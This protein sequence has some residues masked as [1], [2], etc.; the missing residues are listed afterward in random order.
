MRRMVGVLAVAA[1]ALC[2]GEE[3]A[4]VEMCAPGDLL[5]RWSFSGDLLDSAGGLEGA[6]SGAA[7][8]NDA[9]S[10]SAIT[11]RGGARGTSCVDLGFG[12]FPS[13]GG[14]VTIEV[15]ATQNAFQNYSRV[16]DIGVDSEEYLTVTWSRES[17]PGT[18][19]EKLKAGTVDGVFLDSN[20]MGGFELGRRFHV[21]L[22]LLPREDGRTEA[23]WAKRDAE[24][25]ALLGGGSAVTSIRWS[26]KDLAGWQFLL[27][28]S[29]YSNDGDASATYDEVRV[30]KAAL[31]E[32][33]LATSARM[34]A[35]RLPFASA[36]EAT[37]A[38]AA[39]G[40]GTV[41]MAGGAPGAAASARLG[42]AETAQ[43]A[44][45][46]VEGAAFLR[47]TGDLYAIARGEATNPVVTVSGARDAALAA[48]FIAADEPATAV[49]TGG[50]D[51]ASPSDPANWECR[52]YAGAVI[53]GAVPCAKTAVTISGATTFSCPRGQSL[54]CASLVVTNCA[55]AADC[56][57]RGLGSGFRIC[58]TLNLNGHR[59]QTADIPG[60]GTI[61]GD[62]AL[63][64]SAQPPAI[65]QNAC[66]WL[67]AADASTIERDAAGNVLSWTSKDSAHR[68]ARPHTIPGTPEAEN[69]ASAIAPSYG[70]LWGLP[71][72]DFGATGSRR[73][74]LYD[75]FTNLRTVFLAIRIDRYSQRAFL[76]GDRNNGSGVYNFHRGDQGQYGHAK[77]SIYSAVWDGPSQVVPYSDWLDTG[78][79]VI[80]I[81]TSRNACSDSLTD[82]RHIYDGQRTGGRHLFELVCFDTVLADDD[83]QAVAE[84]LR[85]KWM[86]SRAP[87]VLEVDVE[88]GRTVANSEM[89]ILANARFVKSG[90]GTFR[91]ARVQ[92][93][94][95][96]GTEIAAGTYVSTNNGT[97]QDSGTCE[98]EILVR[99][100]AALELPGT[101]D[102]C[103]YHFA[104]DG[105][106]IRYTG[107]GLLGPGTSQ[108][109]T[110]TLSAD[111][112]I[113]RFDFIGAGYTPVRADLGGRVLTFGGE[114]SNI[115]NTELLNGTLRK[116]A[117]LLV[118]DK[119]SLRATS[120]GLDIGCPL[121]L[122]VGGDVGN[123][124]VRTPAVETAAAGNGVL[125]VHGAYRPE[126]GYI[127]NFA[128]ADGS[129]LDVS[130]LDGAF[131]SFNDLTG[132]AVS[133]VSGA[134]V[135]VDA[136]GRA[137][138]AGER[139]VAWRAAPSG[140]TFRWDDATAAA[141][142]AQPVAAADGLYCGAPGEGVVTVAHWTGGA[143]DGD[144]ANA[145]NWACTNST[146]LAVA[147]G[148]PGAAAEVHLGGSVDAQFPE[149]AEVR[150]LGV[151]VGDC[152][153]AADCDWRG[154]GRAVRFNG[155]VDLLGHKLRVRTLKGAGGITDSSLPAGEAEAGAS[156]G[157]LHIDV[158]E[159]ASEINTTVSIGGNLRLVKDGAGE[160]LPSKTEQGFIGGTLVAGG[161]LRMVTSGDALT[162]A[163][164]LRELGAARSVIEVK[165]GAEFDFAGNYDCRQ[166]A[167]LLDGGTIANRGAD[168]THDAYGSGHTLHLA[169]DSRMDMDFTYMNWGRYQGADIEF[170]FGG[171]TLDATL[172]AGKQ[173][174]FF[175]GHSV[176]NGT[177]RLSGDGWLRVD[178]AASD[179]RTADFVMDG[180][181]FSLAY[182]LSVRDYVV[183]RDGGRHEG[184]AALNVHGRFAP[185]GGGFYPCTLQ[186][187]STL[188]LSACE[189]T[190]CAESFSCPGMDV[191]FARNAEVA[192]ELGER[193]PAA[194]ERLVAWREKPV[195]AE[196]KWSEATAAR[197][198]QPLLATE[199]GLFYGGEGADTLVT[200]AQWTGGGG[201][202]DL[203]N[204]ANWSCRNAAGAAVAGGVPGAA[205]TVRVEGLVDVQFP[206]GSEGRYAS[207][208]IGDCR[209]AADCD[210]RG[211]EAPI[212]STVDLDGH[213]LH[214]SH[215]RGSGEIT[216]V[217][218]LDSSATAP[219]VTASAVFWLDAADLS[220][221]AIDGDG[222]VTSWT[223]KDSSR[224]V[225][226]ATSAPAWNSDTWGVPTVDFGAAGSGKDMTYARLTGL[227]T[228]F[229]AIK[230]PR[231]QAAFLLGD[232]STFNFHRGANGQYGSN[233]NGWSQYAAIWNGT[234]P[235]TIDSEYLPD[236]TF[237][238]VCA[239]MKTGNS[240]SLTSDRNS[241]N[242]R[243]GG[244]QLSELICFNAD[245]GD[246][247][248][249]A[250]TEYLQKKWLSRT[251]E[252]H[253]HVPE[254]ET[255]RDDNIRL[256]LNL[257]FVKDGDG[258]YL[259]FKTDHSYT[260]GTEVAGGYMRARSNA[261]PDGMG[262][263][264]AVRG[265]AVFDIDGRANTSYRVGPWGCVVTLDGGTV[266]NMDADLLHGWTMLGNMRLE[267]DSTILA[268][269]SFGF[270][271]TGHNMATIDLGGHE[272][273]VELGD[274]K[275]FCLHNMTITEGRFTVNGGRWLN[276]E[277]TS[278]RAAQA[279][280]DLECAVNVAV[281][282]TM[283]DYT[284]RNAQ[285]D[286]AGTA[287]L[288]VYGAFRPL[289]DF[290]YGC[291]LQNGATLDISSRTGEWSVKS[292]SAG[293]LG[294]VTFAAGATVAVDLHGR[295]DIP[296]RTVRVVAW[297]AR[298]E[299]VEFVLA[300]NSAKYRIYVEN[301]GIY[302]AREGGTVLFLR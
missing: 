237:Q 39:D 144:A 203:G 83:R 180:A 21:S 242:G 297:D 224:R 53:P 4:T 269:A 227:K 271:Y 32:A 167:V 188:D 226:T 204:P 248:R 283:R 99:P 5:H 134:T 246:A 272:L 231:V 206:P 51:G 11:L 233:F 131:A 298:P 66:F 185:K 171:H 76:L 292:A 244:R 36:G 196:F 273:A 43:L 107:A 84:Y 268:P 13:S 199:E 52:S 125:T 15:W 96:G 238:V 70:T 98:G 299:N 74:M 286:N 75:R 9:E 138:S 281:P 119:T 267:G 115:F 120:A 225:A 169:R 218:G 198:A 240:N 186:D 77:H 2:A 235:V 236:C 294:T 90:A 258:S 192:V 102:Y 143:G 239:K 139:V 282:T 79:H 210:W 279:D 181:S 209:L 302:A 87:G 130:G 216:S 154:L 278:V 274:G 127:H 179:S 128:M 48:S 215:L 262:Y 160:F 170:D 122:T 296:Q 31:T 86:A 44:A 291:A 173:M 153:L 290:F 35:D 156:S 29:F 95:S 37:V 89:A 205:A 141:A 100:G 234:T 25:G 277:Q 293:G 124:T 59:L 62:Y 140:V 30:W 65:V 301:D 54:A 23:K 33:Q 82:D 178:K 146:G 27:G 136:H 12:C 81:V 73:D 14:P 249:V 230:I 164:Y 284:V 176:S 148:V 64:S 157:E 223:S 288:E 265:G 147:G 219:A 58:G 252:L 38:A 26:T 101:Q 113:S 28:R 135:T 200:F 228:V 221:M 150:Y 47:W 94:Y 20:T 182:P 88:E 93:T 151:D 285:Y 137:L 195:L 7:S 123:L 118:I 145:A 254:G 133:F 229:W 214:L 126:G 112:A 71:T 166:Y 129:T 289:T 6:A 50:G 259:A 300:P 187:G 42:P 190:F 257:R 243:S 207:V 34:G 40:E 109:D 55:L 111:S 177:L 57:W 245:L 270:V 22:V 183:E 16:F 264:L 97:G 260:R 275:S 46:P 175:Y 72:V 159:G 152:T 19:V 276:F 197:A 241:I 174:R 10:P 63:D 193:T 191:S 69:I 261:Y 253:L 208:E 287:A 80:S 155:T 213:K 45:M 121:T 255:V 201:D 78:L 194:G 189:G 85:R 67:D 165:E 161:S 60:S 103:Q 17:T 3:T 142:P 162:H 168:M 61:L 110:L 91:T 149:G 1:A 158:P 250:V 184:F 8:W 211:L 18:D 49:W 256:T 106:A 247:E 202:G 163:G 220:T 251:G 24:T 114:T 105:G 68:V 92:Q 117:G 132:K 116:D 108:L 212:D 41:S 266:A 104:L 295:R 222:L 217:N 172:G 263:T 232:S 56:D 280:F